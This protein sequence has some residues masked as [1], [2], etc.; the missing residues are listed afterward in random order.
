[1]SLDQVS[2]YMRVPQKRRGMFLLRSEWD[3]PPQE[4]LDK[5]R[6]LSRLR[7]G[8]DKVKI[9]PV[10]APEPVEKPAIKLRGETWEF[11]EPAPYDGMPNQTV[12][13]A[14]YLNIPERVP[15]WKR[16]ILQVCNRHGITYT[17]IISP[18]REVRLV[19]ARHE[20]MWRLK[21]ETAM[22]FPAIGRRFDRDHTTV[23]HAV[24]VH[25][26]RMLKG[27]V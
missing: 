15:E 3:V 4:Q 18:R 19:R 16:I 6:M 11:H 9:V 17:E 7:R 27:E 22:S 10:S 2:A 1:M 20:A 21:N 5:E 25:E 24:R 14:I 8:G 23:L 13:T 26:E 12:S